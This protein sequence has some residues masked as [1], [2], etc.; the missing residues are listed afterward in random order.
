VLFTAVPFLIVIALTFSSGNCQSAPV[1]V[2]QNGPPD[3]SFPVSFV[4]VHDDAG[5]R[6]PLISGRIS[7]MVLV[8]LLASTRA[9]VRGTNCNFS[10]ASRTRSAFS[11]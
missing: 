8:R 4:D 5:L 3:Q 9:A 2:H 6:A 11:A 7:P 1:G 10:M